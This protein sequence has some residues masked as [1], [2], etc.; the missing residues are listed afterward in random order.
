MQKKIFTFDPICV[1]KWQ[2]KLQHIIEMSST[3]RF[4]AALSITIYSYHELLETNAF[5]IA[6]SATIS[7]R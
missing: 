1:S 5:V 4:T 7:I 6:L 2:H 3:V